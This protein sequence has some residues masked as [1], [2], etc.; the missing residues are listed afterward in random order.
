[1]FKK[2]IAL[3]VS[4][5]VLSLFC[6]TVSVAQQQSSP[7][8]SGESTTNP[9]DLPVRSM[10]AITVTATR[11]ERNVLDVPETVTVIT[12]EQMEDHSITNIQELVRH[13]PGVQVNRIT[14]GV[15]PWGNLPGFTIRGVGGNRI[16]T[17]VD[18]SRV[19]ESIQD[20]NRDFV[21]L[22]MMKTVEI[23]RGPGSVLWGA[24]AMGGIV[25]YQTMD[26]ADLL[27]GRAFGAKGQVGYDSMNKGRSQNAM[28]GFQMAPQLSWLLG[29]T[30]R[31]Y[32]EA[33]LGRAR[34]D[35]G[36]WGCTRVAL[37]CDE[38]NPLDAETNNV[39]GKLVWTPNNMHEIKLIGEYF[40]SES[41]VMQLYDKGMTSAGRL[42]GDYPR[43]QA[44]TRKRVAL[45]HDW[46]VSTAFLD[47]VKWKVSYSPQER[48][49]DSTR[50]QTVIATGNPYSARDSL[51]YEE[52]FLQADIQLSSSFELAG[53]KHGLTYGF[54]GDTTDTKY[55]RRSITNNNG[56]ITT[57]YGGG[58]NFTNST[59]D[60]ADVYIQDDIK[61]FN[62]R[63]NLILGLRYATYSIDPEFSGNYVVIPGKEPRKLDE[64]KLLPQLGIIL[65]LTDQYSLYARYAEG[66]KMP[67]AQQLFVSMPGAG[68]PGSDM[69][70]NPN[71][72]PEEVKSYE[73]GVRGKFE[74]GWFSFGGF[75]SDYTDFIRNF[76]EVP[77]TT[78]PGMVDY[79]NLNIAKVKLWGV[80][81]SGEWQFYRNWALNGSASYQHGKEKERTTN[82]YVPFSGAS[83][84]NATLGLKW[85]EPATK[86]M[87]ELIGTFSNSVSRRQDQS[88][89][90]PGGY[91]V[92]DGYVNW[93]ID[94]TF[95]LNA[96]VLNLLNK[97]YFNYNAA[98][99]SDAPPSTSVR[100][101][102]P[103]E[104]YTMPGRTFN[105]NLMASF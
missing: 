82:H 105:V 53:S 75:Y 70:P 80:E 97:R 34:S 14:S 19:I 90:K 35:G 43:H 21:D 33:E 1:M 72:K 24:D 74:K 89:F 27:M 54:Q 25:S 78:N 59:T 63:L 23:M 2:K 102:N 67:T 86:I 48:R 50:Y 87:A 22:S 93:Q 92:F 3:H 81:A 29:Y 94:K 68:G 57:T 30:H 11:H 77:S 42:Y 73:A 104:L 6:G 69:I 41:D 16:Q 15:D 101:T 28:L 45:E 98:T 100:Y 5:A 76:Q 20:G 85:R 61:L 66:F 18:G 88:Y 51:K 31:T 83:P 91:T 37:R 56:A 12:R 103:L 44:Q 96:S 38:L 79:T 9:A 60:R 65:N 17:Q 26:P 99:L 49:L 52:D 36:R 95:R 84:F 46:K 58:A 32:H 64:E 7:V 55:W 10:S 13:Q 8:S 40:Q 71:L 4:L 62:N 39:L 47:N